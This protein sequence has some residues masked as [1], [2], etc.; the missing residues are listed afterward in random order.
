MRFHIH[1]LKTTKGKT[2]DRKSENI[3]QNINGQEQSTLIEAIF[4]F[5]NLKTIN[6]VIQQ[7]QNLTDC[8]QTVSYLARG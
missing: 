1:S 7:P 6:T 4:T 8:L 2:V 5:L 3:H